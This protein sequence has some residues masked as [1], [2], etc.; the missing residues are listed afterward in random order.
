MKIKSTLI[1]RYSLTGELLETYESA[2]SA[3]I[4]LN[5]SSHTISAA[6]RRD[7]KRL[8][9]RGYV[10]RLGREPNIDM[11]ITMKEKWHASS[12]LAKLQ[13]RVGQYDLDGNLINT[14]RNTIEAAKAIGVHKASI[15]KV[16]TGRGLTCGGFVWSS[17]IR[18]KI[19]VSPMI[20]ENQRV[21]SQYDLDGRWIRSF[22]NGLTATRET[23]IGNDNICLAIKGTT[24][25]AGGYLWRKGQKLRVNIAELRN[26]PAFEGSLVHL[27]IK[28]K[29]K[30]A[31]VGS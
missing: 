19:K 20:A 31:K 12:P 9:A 16:M 8:T 4:A 24:L 11:A 21:I 23:G 25:T 5:C 18:N 27:H 29:R 14:F 17:T 10:W 26:H 30:N 2:T 1:S 7:G 13:N 6:A 3:S 28:A 22:K 15:R